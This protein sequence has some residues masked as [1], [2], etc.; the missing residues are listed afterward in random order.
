MTGDREVTVTLTAREARALARCANLATALLGPESPL[1]DGET[2][3]ASESGAMKLE[4]VL[5]TEGAVL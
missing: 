3:R 2:V 1:A 5:V 4:T